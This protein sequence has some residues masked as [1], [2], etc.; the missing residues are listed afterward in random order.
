M[1]LGILGG[2]FDPIHWGHLC[3]A[4][5]VREQ[6]DLE[7]I[8]FIPAGNPPHRERPRASAQDRLAMV[9]LALRGQPMF[10]V[11]DWEIKRRGK[12]YTIDTLEALHGHFP[13]AHLF[14]ILGMDQMQNLATW[15]Q[16]EKLWTRSH[17]IVLPRPG[18]PYPPPYRIPSLAG[19]PIP[20]KSFTMGRI[21]S[22]MISASD[23]R[24]RI[25]QKLSIRY[26]VPQSVANYI[27]KNKLYT[28]GS[29]KVK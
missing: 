19:L 8:Y 2:T 22:L 11:L 13:R 9:R 21:H 27:T 16:P 18:H 4:E 1:R 28:H 26:L 25:Y 6:F 5:D 17:L 23:I 3:A 12:S 14:L 20:R 15:H 7:C 10:K 29:S 24:Q